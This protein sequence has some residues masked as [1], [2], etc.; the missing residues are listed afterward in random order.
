MAKAASGSQYRPRSF[1]STKPYQRQVCEHEHVFGSSVIW[2][3]PLECVCLVRTVPAM[4]VLRQAAV[5]CAWRLVSKNR[6]TFVLLLK[7]YVAFRS[8]HMVALV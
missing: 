8:K 7:I 5:S 3:F 2:V 4:R 1:I 6:G